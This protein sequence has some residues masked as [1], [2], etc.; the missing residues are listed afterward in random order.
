M[1][2]CVAIVFPRGSLVIVESHTVNC[3]T[4][5]YKDYVRSAWMAFGMGS[6]RYGSTEGS[7]WSATV[8]IWAIL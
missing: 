6:R 7:P 5:A 2:H 4:L 8:D 3:C 1:H